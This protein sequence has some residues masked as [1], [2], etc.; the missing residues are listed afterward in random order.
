MKADTN[1]L[2]PQPVKPTTA[3]EQVPELSYL[4]I[5]PQDILTPVELAKRLKVKV[6]WVREKTRHRALVRD[7]DPL[8]CIRM[9]RY[10]RFH[11]PSVSAWLIRQGNNKE[12]HKKELTGPQ[13]SKIM[14]TQHD[15]EAQSRK[16]ATAGNEEARQDHQAARHG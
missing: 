6:S 5:D 15:A 4:R 11:W 12:A 7:S 8:P 16:A 3:V 1:K 9:G 2:A 13:K 14:G 10:I